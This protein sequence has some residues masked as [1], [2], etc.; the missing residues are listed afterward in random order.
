MVNTGQAVRKEGAVH[1]KPFQVM[2]GPHGQPASRFEALMTRIGR[3]CQNSARIVDVSANSR[4]VQKILFLA[5]LAMRHNLAIPAKTSAKKKP[6]R[7]LASRQGSMIA[8]GWARNFGS[9]GLGRGLKPLRAHWAH[10]T[11]PWHLL[12]LLRRCLFHNRGHPA[13]LLHRLP[14]SGTVR[15]GKDDVGLRPQLGGSENN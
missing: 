12:C 8:P 4:A 6:A 14:P 13:F 1:P 15:W 11:V 10:G 7:R 2:A 9:G 3:N 5:M